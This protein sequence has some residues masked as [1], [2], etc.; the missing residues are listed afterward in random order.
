M[1]KTLVALA[2]LAAAGAASAQTYT[3]TGAYTFGWKSVSDATGATTAGFG[4]DTASIALTAKEDLGNGLTATASIGAGGLQRKASSLS[5]KAVSAADPLKSVQATIP[6]S[7]GGENAT[8]TLAGGFGTVIT[9]TSEGSVWL[10]GWQGPASALDG[11][12][13]SANS[14]SDSITYM[15][16]AIGDFKFSVTYAEDSAAD[17]ALGFGVGHSGSKTPHYL[18]LAG[19]YASGPLMVKA[20]YGNWGK[21]GTADNLQRIA[22]TYDMGVVKVGGGYYQLNYKAP[23]TDRTDVAFGATVPLGNVTLGL[24]W[25]Q[26]DDG[27]AP[28]QT[29]TPAVKKAAKKTTG[30]SVGASYALSKSM[31]AGLTYTTWKANTDAKTSN[32]TV[33]DRKSV[34]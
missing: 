21:D 28:D 30:T 29:V 27:G 20:S 3:L 15:L 13:H 11:K 8:L 1:K 24:N 32:E 16:P 10:S 19:T 33:L 4:T 17:T 23:G 14:A 9:S 7:V 5:D 18:S 6:G 25:A 12:V 26:R 22:A 34:V 2:V 31:S